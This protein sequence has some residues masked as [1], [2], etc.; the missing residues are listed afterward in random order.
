MKTE[1]QTVPGEFKLGADWP[2][3]VYPALNEGLIIDWV[4]D[5]LPL[6]PMT[7]PWQSRTGNHHP[8]GPV[9]LMDS[10]AGI[11][12]NEVK[13]DANGHKYLQ[14]LAGQRLRTWTINWAI[15][16]DVTMMAVVRPQR[17]PADSGLGTNSRL[18]SG[19]NGG[20][21]SMLH[22][23]G[24]Y[25]IGVTG[26]TTRISSASVFGNIEAIMGRYG[27]NMYDGKQYGGKLVTPTDP[28]PDQKSVQEYIIVGGNDTTLA[29]AKLYG[30][31][32]RISIWDRQ[33]TDQEMDAALADQ[34]K[35]YG[36]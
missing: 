35:T 25:S 4:A 24:T 22:A 3:L 23:T 5:D 36:F 17:P 32:F 12:P 15:D 8:L 28:F 26:K 20:F 10:E 29:N 30:D 9:A 14:I 16:Q 1:I 18:I 31:L 27:K 11:L 7:A 21:R 6:G 2:K 13:L 34:A 19:A 33:L